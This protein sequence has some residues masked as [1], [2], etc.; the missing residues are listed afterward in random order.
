M[1]AGNQQ[2]LE[3]ELALANI[4]SNAVKYS[5]NQPVSMALAATDT[6]NIIIVKDRGIGIPPED[7]PYI[8]SPFFRASNTER[9]EGYGIG[10]P[11]TNNIIRMHKGEISVSSRM[12]E[13]T[14]IK[15][16]LPSSAREQ[17]RR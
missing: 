2:L 1:P 8:F 13:G 16:V 4:V 11:L 12:N 5:S 10:L 9:F 7:L 17:G 3:L 14:E 6:R 15:V